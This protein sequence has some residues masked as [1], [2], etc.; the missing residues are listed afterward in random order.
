MPPCIRPIPVVLVKKRAFGNQNAAV[1]DILQLFERP[2]HRIPQIR[3]QRHLQSISNLAPSLR[4]LAISCPEAPDTPLS[5]FAG[6]PGGK[7]KRPPAMIG[8][9]RN[10]EQISPD[11]ILLPATIGMIFAGGRLPSIRPSSSAD[12]PLPRQTF[13][14]K[15]RPGVISRKSAASNNR[16]SPPHDPCARV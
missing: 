3:D 15:N 1:A 5:A 10:R 2:A 14:Q 4:S 13:R 9:E 11:F 7:S 12:S 6:G 8:L 16:Q